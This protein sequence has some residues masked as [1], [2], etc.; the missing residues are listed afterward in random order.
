LKKG[1]ESA[2]PYSSLRCSSIDWGKREG[3]A[4]IKESEFQ[5]TCLIEVL[6]PG[7][8]KKNRRERGYLHSSLLRLRRR[9]ESGDGVVRRRR[10]GSFL[11]A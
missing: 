5:K 7:R 2:L 9:K 4:S 8:K 1:G 3:A 6:L 11:N 10:K